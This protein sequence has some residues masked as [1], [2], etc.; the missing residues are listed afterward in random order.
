M[1]DEE[2]I[3]TE[4][5]LASLPEKAQRRLVRVTSQLIEVEVCREYGL[6]PGS[7]LEKL[8]DPLEKD[9]GPEAFREAAERLALAN[10]NPLDGKTDRELWDLHQDKIKGGDDGEE[11]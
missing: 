1:A 3:W 4:E 2:L 7:L 6:E 9:M 8:P 11:G 5:F 10:S